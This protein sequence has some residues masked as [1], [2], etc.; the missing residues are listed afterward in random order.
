M[1]GCDGYC[2]QDDCWER[3]LGEVHLEDLVNP[4]MLGV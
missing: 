1:V 4:I 2:G 3:D